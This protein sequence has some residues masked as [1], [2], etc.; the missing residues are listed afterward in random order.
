MRGALLIMCGIAGTIN[1]DAQK[2]KDVCIFMRNRGPDD[3]H[4]VSLDKATLGCSRLAIID[5]YKGR[6]PLSNEKSDLWVV[7]NGE[8]YNYL[9]LKKDLEG[10]G[11][12]IITDSDTE[13]LVHSYEEWGL[14]FIKK[15]RGMFALAIWDDKLARLILATD[16]YGKKPLYFCYDNN[17]FW[18]A[19]SLEALMRAGIREKRPPISDHAIN[20]YFTYGY[21]PAPFTIYEGIYKL[22]PSTLLIV[23]SKREVRLYTLHY[24]D[25][26]LNNATMHSVAEHLRE[27]MSSIKFRLR[28]D[29]P[30]AALLSGGMDSSLITTITSFYTPKLEAFTIRFKEITLDE[31]H[32]AEKLAEW[33]NIKHKVVDCELKPDI[34]D[35]LVAEIDEPFGDSSLIPTHIVF[36][37]INRAGYKVTLTGDGGDEILFG[38][39]WMDIY[40]KPKPVMLSPFYKLLG[41]IP[42]KYGLRAKYLSSDP[43]GRYLFK[44]CKIAKY[45]VVYFELKKAFKMYDD[46]LLASNYATIR[47][48]LPY[49]ILTKVDRA[50]MLTSVE[51]RCPMLDIVFSSTVLKLKR[52]PPLK[53][54]GREMLKSLKVPREIWDRPKHGFRVNVKNW[55]DYM[56]GQ[57]NKS[58]SPPSRVKNRPELLYIWCFIYLWRD[59][60]S[61]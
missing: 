4:M 54:L 1:G 44:V 29:V 25:P 40:E 3:L 43:L 21:I 50:S 52:Y 55:V 41:C 53:K 28:A 27:L 2:V 14:R 59:F 57:L 42:N 58:L 19:S 61:L 47:S 13:V 35:H 31:S 26:E 56:M 9:E 33:L 7:Q 22:P 24:W 38:Y 36:K 8:I 20:Y 6:Q 32:Y 48:Y 15:L 17:E 45:P 11:H 49:D 30:I 60:R 46:P 18:F 34:L 37:A 5:I 23:E 39:P 12:N 10:S 51:A 16:W